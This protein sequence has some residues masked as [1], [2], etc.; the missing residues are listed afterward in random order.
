MDD[1]LGVLPCCKRLVGGH[2]RQRLG[3]SVDTRESAG[4]EEM[5]ESECKGVHLEADHLS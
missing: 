4:F 3:S 2:W 5:E 1:M